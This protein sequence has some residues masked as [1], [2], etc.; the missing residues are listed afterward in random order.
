MGLHTGHHIPL[1]R[2]PRTVNVDW[3]ALYQTAKFGDEKWAVNYVAEVRGHELATR[4]ELLRTQPDHPR[5]DEQ[6]YKLQ[7]GPL[8]RLP[9]SIPSRRWRRFTFLH[10]TGERLMAAEELNDLVVQSAER[11]M[12]YKASRE[13]GLIAE[14][15]YEDSKLGE[16]DLAL[17]CELGKLGITL[18]EPPA[19]RIKER[20]G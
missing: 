2:A 20:R 8:T 14:R 11:E 15:Q 3:L 13:R 1:K 12:L 9:R 16:V 6:Y 10:T 5:A 7:L 18:G 4:A 17:L 19:T